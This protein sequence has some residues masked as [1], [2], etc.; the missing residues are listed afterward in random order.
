MNIVFETFIKQ[1][2][3]FPWRHRSG[4]SWKDRL[5]LALM[6]YSYNELS[7]T[8]DAYFSISSPVIIP[9]VGF[10]LFGSKKCDCDVHAVKLPE[11]K[12]GS[13]TCQEIDY[14]FK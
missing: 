7:C 10:Q 4:L 5:R 8:M 13:F 2:K 14:Y 3:Q 11:S 12:K 1:I 6:L 9:P